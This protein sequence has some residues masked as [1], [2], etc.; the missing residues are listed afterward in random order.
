V[1]ALDAAHW[2]VPLLVAQRARSGEQAHQRIVDELTRALSHDEFA[3]PLAPAVERASAQGVA[4]LGEPKHPI[5]PDPPGAT[6][7]SLSGAQV[8]EARSKLDELEREQGSV[9]VDLHWTITTNDAPG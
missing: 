5:R 9:Q 4:L 2:Q 3:E 1:Q 6:R 7:G 8:G